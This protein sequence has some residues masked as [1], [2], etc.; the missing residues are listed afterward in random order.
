[1]GDDIDQ[2]KQGLKN[3]FSNIKEDITSNATKI[4]ELINQ[5]KELK[6]TI[7]ELE[8]TIKKLVNNQSKDLLKEDMLTKIKRN[9]KEI[10]K[11]RILELIQTER[12]SIPEIKDIVVDRDNYCSKA[13]F[14]RY[15][16]DIKNKIEGIKIGDK[17]I[18]VPIKI[19]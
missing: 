5:N 18:V 3:S 11:A 6:D 12:Y 15:I 19:N 14:Y 16:S 10:V 4:Q 17:Q 2:L 7:N 13:T 9:R 8:D 1:M